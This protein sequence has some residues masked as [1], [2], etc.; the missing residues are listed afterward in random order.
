MSQF[1]FPRF[2]FNG[3]ID[4]NVGT[5]NNDDYSGYVFTKD[6]FNPPKPE[7]IGKPLRLA[8]SVYV[9]PKTFG[10]TDAEWLEW[11]QNIQK[12]EKPDQNG[13]MVPAQLIPAEW[14][15]YGGMGL[16]MKGVKV[17][18]VQTAI[19]T[20]DANS[21]LQDAELS[22]NMRPG[23]DMAS[24]GVICDVNPENVPSSQ[25]IATN[26]LLEKNG[27]ALMSGK[28]GKGSTRYINFQRNVVATAS[29]GA[30]GVVYHTITKEELAGQEILNALGTGVTGRSDFKGVLIRYTLYRS[31][32]P[33]GGFDYSTDTLDKLV[34]LY[35]TGG[36]NAAELQITGTIAPWYD[37]EFQSIT[38]CRNMMPEGTYLSPGG[39][40]KPIKP[41]STETYF[42]LAP[43]LL[44][45]SEAQNP[46]M[47]LD[48][49]NTF[50]EQYDSKTGTNDKYNM[51][52]I[53]LRIVTKVGDKYNPYKE[54][55]PID[56]RTANYFKRGGIID[57]DLST[58]VAGIAASDLIGPQLYLELYN[59][60]NTVLLR[61]TDYMIA[62]DTST[63]YGE[64]EAGNV[65][66]SKFNFNGTQVESFFTVYY[67]GK[68]V[69]E[70]PGGLTLYTYQ[71]T[72][73]QASNP[74]K[75]I[76]SNPYKPGQPISTTVTKPGNRLFYC[77]LPGETAPEFGNLPLV[78]IPLVTLRILPNEDYDQYY[79]D[80]SAEQPVANDTLTFDILY[81]KVLRNYYL[82]YPAMS[83]HVPLNDENYW[84]GPD[85]VRRMYKR[86]QMSMWPE[87]QYM[88]RTR[89]LSESRRKL[90]Q[91]WC[92]KVIQG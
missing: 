55:G 42:Q 32:P 82:L 88:P 33:I 73:N 23:G 9:E 65:N 56:Y 17:N 61:E 91:A 25:F 2:H 79:V 76:Y 80:P 69:N 27:D 43:V 51:G 68:Q 30:S 66:Q 11:T 47:S 87:T 24:T 5:G 49:I 84:N 38:M 75:P 21:S 14:N 71:A 90:L 8:D 45:I 34:E 36:L 57:I 44:N 20:F 54:L 37:G 1:D 86:I 50:P 53:S 72:P 52:T 6:S 81:E 89:D 74:K 62:S 19:D 7:F 29:A 58:A 70:V 40:G 16:T 4:V 22:F 46:I 13:K 92:L 31:M 12:F 64:Q 28:P 41:P 60:K 26:M 15:Y 78:R 3:M 35:K 59:D 77:A 39:N 67:R 10:M 48:V 18:S 63:I 83:K 85:M